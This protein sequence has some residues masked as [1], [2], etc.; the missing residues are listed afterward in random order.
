V[1]AV[2]P[3]N[4]T[5]VVRG[6][7]AMLRRLLGEQITITTALAD[8]LDPVMAD[9]TQLEQL[10][11]NLSVNARDAMPQGG[12]LA[13]ATRNITLDAGD[14]A[15]HPGA[16]AGSYASLRVT[17]T[18]TGM[19]VEKQGR[20]FEPFFTTKERGRGTGLGLA[21]VHGIVRQLGGTSMFRAS[22]RSAARS[23][24][25]CPRLTRRPRGVVTDRACPGDVASRD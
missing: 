2:A 25:T 6:V 20:I 9:I 8:D 7:E 16:K 4:I 13:L 19:S 15:A 24:S 12:R 18:G 11:V 21:A 10:L 22:R 5:T 17:D 3:L 14:V 1:L 23:R